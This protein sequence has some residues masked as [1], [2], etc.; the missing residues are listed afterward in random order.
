MTVGKKDGWEEGDR[1]GVKLPRRARSP[2]TNAD[3]ARE[4]QQEVG[5]AGRTGEKHKEKG[6]QSKRGRRKTKSREAQATNERN[7][8]RAMK[9]ATP[10][11]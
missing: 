5:P 4:D 6:N 11:G 2:S 3:G 7:R 8:K 10:T 9:I 1:R